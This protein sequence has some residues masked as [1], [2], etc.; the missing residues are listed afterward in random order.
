MRSDFWL[1]GVSTL[2]SQLMA[3]AC[4]QTTI[5]TECRRSRSWLYNLLPTLDGK[6]DTLPL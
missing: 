5:A 3:R 6:M 2:R 4:F 1:A